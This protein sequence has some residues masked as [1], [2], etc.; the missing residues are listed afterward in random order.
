MGSERVRIEVRDKD[1]GLVSVVR[2]QPELDYDIDYL[3]GRVLLTE[4]ISIHRGRSRCWCAM[5]D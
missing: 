1:S 2:L 3:Q 5:T 4:P